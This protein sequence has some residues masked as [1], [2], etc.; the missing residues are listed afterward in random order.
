V[1][2]SAE[3]LSAIDAMLTASP[4]ALAGFRQRFPSLSLTRC[5]ATDVDA[6]VPFRR[7]SQVSL[8]LVDASAHCWRMTSDLARATGIVVA[9]HSAAQ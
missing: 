2:I 4:D 7:Y 1:A 3:D 6:E 5:D 9:R 8:F